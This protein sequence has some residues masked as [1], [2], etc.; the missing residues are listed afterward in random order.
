M[1]TIEIIL[2]IIWGACFLCLVGLVGWIFAV[3]TSDFIE[4][5]NKENDKS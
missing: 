1:G 2:L 4:K 3:V 5:V